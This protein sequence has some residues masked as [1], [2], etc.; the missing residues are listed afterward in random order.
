MVRAGHA[1]YGYVSPARGEA[2]AQLLE[3]QPALTWKAKLVAVKEI[4]EGALVGYGGTFRAPRP[5]RI[6]DSGRGLRRRNLS[7]AVEPRKSD[8]RRT[9]DADSGHHLHGPDHHRS[10]PHHPLGA[11]RR[12]DAARR[13]RRGQPGRAADRAHGRHHLIQHSVQHQRACPARVRMTAMTAKLLRQYACLFAMIVLTEAMYLRPSI[14]TGRMVMAGSDY[15]QL[16]KA[17]MAFGEEGLFGPRHTLPAWYPREFWDRHTPP[18]CK[19]FRGFPPASCCLLFPSGNGLRPGRG[20]GRVAGGTVHV[21]LLPARGTL[22]SGC[23]RVGMDIRLRR[24][25]RFP[26]D[27]RTPA[28]ARSLSRAA[29]PALAGRSRARPRTTA[30]GSLGFGLAGGGDHL[31]GAGRHPQIPA[32]AVGTAL[33]YVLWRGRGWLRARL[34][35]AMV[36]GGGMALAAWW[37]M[38]LLIQKSTRILDLDPPENDMVFPYRRILA[39]FVPGIDGWPAGFGRQAFSGYPNCSYLFDT[40]SYIGLAPIVAAAALLAICLVRKR[41]PEA[42]FLFLACRGNA[43][44]SSARCRCSDFLRHSPR[45]DP[46]QSRAP[47]LYHY[48]FARGRSGRGRGRAARPQDAHQTGLRRCGRRLGDC[49]PSIS[50]ASRGLGS[51]R[52]PRVRIM[53]TQDESLGKTVERWQARHRLRD[54]VLAPPLRRHRHLRFSH[55]GEAI[56][57]APRS[58][59]GAAPAPICKSSTAQT[60]PR[61]RC[62]REA[63]HWC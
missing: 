55:S 43:P 51:F 57:R 60:C 35:G 8:R 50:T 25:L 13:G 42:R 46:A 3:V 30:R 39:L 29:A 59:P 53:G 16:H 48:V 6:G 45:R 15:L 52:F 20:D 19:A 56:P 7:P 5:M 34:A 31:R 11:R 18:T 36:L 58:Q 14:L 61:P 24:I 9:P 47:A 27:G 38:L 33:L 26:R 10:E 44:P 49:M 22:G 17:R 1:L 32:Y 12:R 37:P 62:E 21:S 23:C 4:P 54:L 63:R 41:K 28:A 40:A 2:P